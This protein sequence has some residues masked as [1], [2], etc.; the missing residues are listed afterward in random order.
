LTLAAAAV[1][2]V[3]AGDAFDEQSRSA[4]VVVLLRLV[5]SLSLKPSTMVSMKMMAYEISEGSR[6][7][8]RD[9]NC[10]FDRD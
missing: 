4:F 2:V 6:S 8:V 5:H 9:L 7:V 10:S 1:A 3:V